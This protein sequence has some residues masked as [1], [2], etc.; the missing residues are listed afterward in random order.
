LAKILIIRAE[1]GKIVES[2][3][4]EGELYSI[5]KTIL[6]SAGGEWNPV[7]SDFIALREVRVVE[8]NSVD[9]DTIEAIK[10]YSL[11]EENRGKF[12][13]TIPVYTISF[14]NRMIS[15]D[16]YIENK[17]YIVTLY[18]NDELKDLFEAEA[19]EI[20]APPKG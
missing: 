7:E 18:V 10:K 6:S 1:E 4:E 13:I 15:E 14:D 17:I 16:S 9:P 8:V 12:K 3:V 2:R 11:V 19:V 5:V 20:T